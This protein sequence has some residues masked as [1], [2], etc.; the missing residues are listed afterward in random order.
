MLGSGC[1]VHSQRSRVWGN[2]CGVWI[3]GEGLGVH[4]FRQRV[5]GSGSIVLGWASGFGVQGLEFRVQGSA[6]MG[7]FRVQ[8]SACMGKRCSRELTTLLWALSTTSDAKSTCV[9][10]YCLRFGGLGF[11]FRVEGFGFRV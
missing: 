11:G 5:Q 3:E 10:V 9:R 8:G 6:C 2:G 4:G 1:M 7:K